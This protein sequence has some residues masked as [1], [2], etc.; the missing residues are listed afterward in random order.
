MLSLIRPVLSALVLGLLWASGVAAQSDAE[1]QRFLATAEGMTLVCE[2]SN[3]DAP[4]A[5]D[6]ASFCHGRLEG[7]ARGMQYNCLSI[8][9]GLASPSLTLSMGDFPSV[10]DLKNAFLLWIKA[11]PA[12]SDAEWAFVALQAF[13]NTFP[14]R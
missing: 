7:L 14:C 5:A 12:E 6:A 11:S 1:L 8:K 4:G 2:I 10:G 3:T 9:Q 13:S